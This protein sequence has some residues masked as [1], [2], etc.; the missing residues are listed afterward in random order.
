MAYSSLYR[1]YRDI[2]D[3]YIG[4][5]VISRIVISGFLCT[6]EVSSTTDR[7]AV[8]RKRKKNAIVGWPVLTMRKISRLAAILSVPR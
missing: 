5:I 2:E 7:H 3:R 6:R 4:D 1:G 8:L